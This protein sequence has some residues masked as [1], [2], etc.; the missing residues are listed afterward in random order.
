M[1]ND[2]VL[3]LIIISQYIMMSRERAIKQ[4]R[5]SQQSHISLLTSDY[6]VT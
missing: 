3:L 6:S 5:A 4:Q 1:L 2:K